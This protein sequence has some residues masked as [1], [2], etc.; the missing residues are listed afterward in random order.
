MTSSSLHVRQLPSAA[1][2]LA[3]TAAFRG[4]DPVMTNLIGSI[5]EGVVAGAR[6]DAE[7]WLVVEDSQV[8][9]GC[10]LRT[11]PW[12][13]VLSA[14]PDPTAEALG[15]WLAGHSTELAALTGP[16]DPVAATARSLGR[17]LTVRMR[18]TIRVL[19]D[20]A[21]PIECAGSI[22]P[23]GPGDVDL[24]LGWFADFHAEAG[25]P[26]P[27]DGKVVRVQIGDGRLWVWEQG[28]PVAM[29]GHARVV[30]T[31]GARVGRIGPV[32][33]PREHRRRGY[34]SALTHAVA[35]S[36][37]SQCDHVML[38]A[39]AA[40]RESNSI[41]ERLGFVAVAEYIEADLV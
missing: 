24:L 30:T 11:A 34:G 18:D 7:L 23:A 38:F 21:T 12:P 29:A 2:W 8:V 15:E 26:V 5:A 32:Y 9:V 6:Y 10:A 25:L 39:D 27:A 35:E 22:R 20:L 3:V 41:Y 31:P 40:N 13:V 14:M 37:T 36:L 16:A 4:R 17:Q 1:E 28:G 33:T 19:G